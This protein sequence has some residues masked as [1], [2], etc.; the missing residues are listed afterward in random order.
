MCGVARSRGSRGGAAASQPQP[1]ADTDGLRLRVATAAAVC[2][3]AG[4]EGA[5]KGREW[6][7]GDVGELVRYVKWAGR[8]RGVRER[9]GTHPLSDLVGRAGWPR[10][11]RPEMEEGRWRRMLGEVLPGVSLDCPQ[12]RGKK[13]KG[14]NA[15]G[16]V[17]AGGVARRRGVGRGRELDRGAHGHQH[18]G[19]RLPGSAGG[20]GRR[21]ARRAAGGEDSVSR[22][23]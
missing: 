18:G 11:R 19:A 2:A 15:A 23:R 17:A 9:R 6:T 20:T 5:P 13:P 4:T 14:S 22:Q 12:E 16:A 8:A 1:A 3:A 7:A 21:E 10:K